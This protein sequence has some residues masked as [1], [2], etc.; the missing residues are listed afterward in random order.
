MDEKPNENGTRKM[1][2]LEKTIPGIFLK[3]SNIVGMNGD[4]FICRWIPYIRQSS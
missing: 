3:S 1:H 4:I 2:S